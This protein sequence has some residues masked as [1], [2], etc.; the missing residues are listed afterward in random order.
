MLAAD[1]LQLQSTLKQQATALKEKEFKLHHENLM[2]VGTQAAVLAGL[3]VTMLIELTPSSDSEWVMLHSTLWFIPRVIK[4]FYYFTISTAFCA[5]I[6]VVGQTTILSVMGA[7]LALRGPDGS[8]MVA[9]D[10]LYDER[11]YV[12]K[13]FAYGL[14]STLCSVIVGVWLILPPESAFVCMMSTIYTAFKLREQYRRV[15]QKFIFDE[16]DTVDFHDLFN[17][18]NN[19]R[20]RSNGRRSSRGGGTKLSR[21]DHSLKSSPCPTPYSDDEEMEYMNQSLA[22]RKRNNAR[23]RVFEN[24]GDYDYSNG[25]DT[26]PLVPIMTV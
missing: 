21:S 5:N 17:V 23:N 15:K 22:T 13:V 6:L 4:L 18:S 9:T 7:S 24:G 2:T 1:K 19:V 8:M 16:E 11:S 3:D 26:I 14:V 20:S 12:F 25:N 10:G